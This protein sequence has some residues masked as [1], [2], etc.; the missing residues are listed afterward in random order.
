MEELYRHI[1]LPRDAASMKTQSRYLTGSDTSLS[2]AVEH[3]ITQLPQNGYKPNN[4]GASV[5]W[6]A[7]Q[8]WSQRRNPETYN[9]EVSV[10]S[11]LDV[12][13]LTCATIYRFLV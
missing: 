4:R 8:R 12:D 3:T 9:A 11:R 13:H 7:Y 2:A 1:D 10:T 6:K 5:E